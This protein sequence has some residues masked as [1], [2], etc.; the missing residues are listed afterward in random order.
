MDTVVLKF[1]GSSVADNDKLLL[2]ARKIIRFVKENNKV[3][4]VVSAQ[5]KKTDSLLNQAYELSQNPNKRELD[6][7][8][9]TG[10]QI[11]I[12]K[13]SILLDELGYESISLTGWQAGI[14]T[15]NVNQD[16]IIEYIDTRRVNKE[17]NSGKIVIVAGFQGL[18]KNLD[19]TTLGR[20]G[21]DTT[22]ISLAAAMN[23]KY[24]YI[25]SDVEGVFTSDPKK[26]SSASKLKE[27]SYDEMLD[28]SNEGAKVLHNRCVEIAKK[29]DI[30]IVAMSTFKCDEGT[31]INN[32]IEAQKIKSIVKDDGLILLQFRK[33]DIDYMTIYK[34]LIDNEIIPVELIS[35]GDKIK[36]LFKS[37]ESK[38]IEYLLQ[39]RFA[40][41]II[42]QKVVSRI[43][44]IGYGISNN[45]QIF[46]K[47]LDILEGEKENIQKIDVNNGKIRITF[48]KAVENEVLEN[49]HNNLI[50]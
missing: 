24:C 9:S 6:V 20:G 35:D 46:S 5:G 11:T 16:A 43:S 4:V 1:G 31:T 22:A 37:S 44:I 2:V 7:L 19:I 36:A 3:V 14:Y 32:K 41:I 33:V 26:L 30:P 21:S 23:A 13:L 47:L 15:N 39:K 48:T 10:E 34:V 18:N 42:E 28:I 27:L 12:S 50:G 8:L 40:D 25:Y 29:F 45:T 38:K 17:L 49:I